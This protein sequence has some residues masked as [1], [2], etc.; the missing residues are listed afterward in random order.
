MTASVPP[1]TVV[2]PDS[3]SCRSA[4]A[5][6]CQPASAAGARQRAREGAGARGVDRQRRIAEV[7]VR[8]SR[9]TA[10][11][12]TAARRLARS[13]RAPLRED[14]RAGRRE[15]ACTGERQRA[16][17]ADRR[18]AGV[19]APVGVCVPPPARE[20]PVP[21]SCRRR[22]RRAGHRERVAAESH[23]RTRRARQGT[24]RLRAAGEGHVE[25]RAVPASV[26]ALPDDSRRCRRPPA[27]CRCRSSCRLVGVGTGERRRRRPLTAR[28]AAARNRPLKPRLLAP[29]TVSVEPVPRF[30][31]LP[32][33]VPATLVPSVPPLPD[34]Q[35]SAAECRRR[36]H[37]QRAA[38]GDTRAA[39]V[40]AGQ[41]RRRRVRDR[42]I[43][44]TGNRAGQ[45]EAVPGR[46]PSTSRS[47]VH[48]IGQ[49][50]PG[51]PAAA[52]RLL[53]SRSARALPK[54]RVAARDQRAATGQ[55]RAA[56]IRVR[57]GQRL[58]ARAAQRQAAARAGDRAAVCRCPNRPASGCCRRGSP[59]NRPRP[60]T[61]SSSAASSRLTSKVA[62]APAG[63]AD[64]CRRLPPH[65]SPACRC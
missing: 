11:R 35:R 3:V 14:H 36:A 18:A 55:V 43:A 39:G 50:V 9:P 28:V 56:R 45:A 7:H 23:G 57:T 33:V 26:T 51:V 60:T 62:P 6:P 2:G 63:S 48:R 59:S 54:R 52:C 25:R 24:R 17:T 44:V 4:T 46:L 22:R 42:Q 61:R 34:V 19:L 27:C 13:A 37:H 20:P 64:C 8:S 12:S 30:T 38:T 47:R 15:A 31:A 32:S 65:R 58:G 41:R 53:R 29:P 5:R 40:G 21:R 49:L 1:A 16:A 10:C